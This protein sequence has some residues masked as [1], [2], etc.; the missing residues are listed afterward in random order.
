M[1]ADLFFNIKTAL[2]I[3]IILATTSAFII[4]NDAKKQILGVLMQII[5]FASAVFV[6]YYDRQ[7]ALEDPSLMLILCL[8]TYLHG[9]YLTI[10][11]TE[12]L[13]IQKIKTIVT[14]K[15]TMLENEKTNGKGDS[16]GH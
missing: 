9:L 12:M 4:K 3:G 6:S 10:C 15:I 1:N 5:A 7:P 16:N 13:T 8:I 14:A 11:S 2:I